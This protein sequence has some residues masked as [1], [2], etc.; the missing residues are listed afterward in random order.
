MQPWL[1]SVGNCQVIESKEEQLFKESRS[2]KVVYVKMHFRCLS[3]VSYP[4]LFV[5]LFLHL[6]LLHNIETRM[7]IR[8][9]LKS[10]LLPNKLLL[11][12]P[13]VLD[14]FFFLIRE[15]L[16]WVLSGCHRTVCPNHSCFVIFWVTTAAPLGTHGTWKWRWHFRND[17]FCAPHLLRSCEGSE[18]VT[19]TSTRNENVSS[20]ATKGIIL[21]PLK[22]RR[23]L[24]SQDL[25]Q[26]LL[27]EFLITVCLDNQICRDILWFF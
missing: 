6:C 16:M 10:A 27:G 11:D 18:C 5:A 25:T 14:F 12:C 17:R 8:F 26:S 22:S 19:S 21:L 3:L 15:R 23:L 4:F 2:E 20:L 24:C 9:T 1:S 13:L 7:F